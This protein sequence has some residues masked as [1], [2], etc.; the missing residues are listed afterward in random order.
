MNIGM[1]YSPLFASVFTIVA[2]DSHQLLTTV[3]YIV[4]RYTN[5]DKIRSYVIYATIDNSSTSTTST[6]TTVIYDATN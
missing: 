6:S 1:T 3:A 2:I 4:C 5:I